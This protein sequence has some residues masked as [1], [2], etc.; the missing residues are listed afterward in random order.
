MIF[1]ISDNHF[2]HFN[3]IRYCNRP[4][5]TAEQMNSHM[6]TEWN[7]VVTPQDTVIVVG[8]FIFYKNN[9]NVCRDMLA[10]LNGKLKILVRGNHDK[11]VATCYQMGFDFVCEKMT[12]MVGGEPVMVCHY[13]R[14]APWWAFWRHRTP[15][16]PRD[17]GQL[18]IH[19]HTHSYNKFQFP[20]SYNVCAE[21]SKYRPIPITEIESWIGKL[22]RK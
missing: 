7:R 21:A 20:K 17:T 12:L 10:Q 5:T 19:G 22:K 4:F 15:R 9:L 11:G 8:D 1:L 13:P 14:Q 2:G 6:I 3:I 18:L 16:A